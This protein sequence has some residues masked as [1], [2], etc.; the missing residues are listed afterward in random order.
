MS[1]QDVR[2]L[3][4]EVEALR[5]TIG[6]LQI[7]VELL[8]SERQPGGYRGEGPLAEIGLQRLEIPVS[9]RLRSSYSRA[10]T[11]SLGSF[12]RVSQEVEAEDTTARVLLA[13]EIG[14]FLSRALSGDFRGTSG[15]DR[16]RLQN[17]I[18]LICADHWG[19]KFNPPLA[20]Y[21]FSEVKS[22]C[23]V[24]ADCGKAVF[25]GFASPWEARIAVSEAGLEVPAQLTHAELP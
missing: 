21:R 7:R 15:R 2:L 19:Q 8:E 18:Y 16:L 1:S 5:A 23:K 12:S 3:S 24:G 20:V 22:R 6:A 4:A 14:A 25:I 13:K 10:S 11:E 9:E 17:A